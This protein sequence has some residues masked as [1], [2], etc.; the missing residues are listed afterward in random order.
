LGFVMPNATTLALSG[1]PR[2]AG[3][4]SA[5]LGVMQYAVGAAAAPLVGLGDRSALQMAIVIAVCG[6][7]ALAVGVLR[8][9]R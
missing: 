7:S 6:V 2:T 1:H 8:A 9:V 5:L 3:S 4:A